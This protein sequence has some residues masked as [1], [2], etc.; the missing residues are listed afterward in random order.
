M[1]GKDFI[2]FIGSRGITTGNQMDSFFLYWL[3]WISLLTSIGAFT[4]FLSTFFLEIN[5]PIGFY[6]FITSLVAIFYILIV[7]LHH[8]NQQV[9]A[10]FHFA[11]IVPW[12]YAIAIAVIGGNFSQSIAAA[13]TLVV[14]LFIYPNRDK[15]FFFLMI[16]NALLFIVPTMYVNVFGPIIGID[17]P[18]DEIV[19]FI[20]CCGWVSIA[21]ISFDRSRSHLIQNLKT[22]NSILNN[23]T[24][25]LHQFSYLMA[26]DIK[27]PIRNIVSFLGLLERALQNNNVEK[28]Q[29]HLQYALKGSKD[30]T[31][32]V[33]DVSK[34]IEL[35]GQDDTREVQNLDKILEST[36][37]NLDNEISQYN[38]QV[39]YESL[40]YFNCKSTDMTLLFQNI[41]MNGL[42][43]NKS[44]QPIVNIKSEQDPEKRIIRFSDNGIGIEQEYQDKI[45]DFFQRLHVKSDYEGTG[46][47]LG[48]CNYIVG[49]YNGHIH[50]ESAVGKGST[51]IVELPC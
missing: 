1:K 21:F 20:L 26:H 40:G 31:S 38:G 10:F 2:D 25:E 43:Y 34:V 29:K 44:N 13:S 37:F 3:N 17:F 50:V 45:F 46:I 15:V 32:L 47:G 16:Y 23:R 35:R 24:A 36:L 5:G 9:I 7:I 11:V 14:I 48:I 27:T 22:N 42:K 6:R 18:F 19:V 30:L 33:D 4:L 39:N 51:F 41:I 8:Y 12:W 28:A 49:K